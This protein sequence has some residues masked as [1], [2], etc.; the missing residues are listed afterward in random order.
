MKIRLLMLAKDRSSLGGVVNFVNILERNL[1]DDVCVEEF[2]IGL[3]DNKSGKLIRWVMPF[4]DMFRLACRILFNRYDV[5]QINPSLNM[6][7][8]FRDALFIL[9]IKLRA[10]SNVVLF[11]HGWEDKSEKTI[12]NCELLKNIFVILFGRA[13]VIYVLA[14]RFKQS[15]VEWGVDADKVH[16]ITTMFDGEHF[17]GVIRNRENNE[18]RLLYLSRFVKEKGVYELLTSFERLYKRYPYIRLVLAGEGPEGKGMQDWVRNS[19][20]QDVVTFVGYVR[21]KDKAQV[22]VDSDIFV[23]PTYYAEGCPVSLLE[24][25]AAGLPIVTSMVGG[26]GDII[27]DGKNGVLLEEVTAGTVETA[28]QKLLENELMRKETGSYNKKIAWKHYEA[29]VISARIE[30]SYRQLVSV[31]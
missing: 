22:L 8:L 24:A 5:I 9:V 14:S 18:I 23:F 13:H 31:R 19:G 26:I 17:N 6:R 16:V 1:S 29:A 28:L 11:V 25:M 3:R 15:L 10:I 30:K 27:A 2:K 4:V 20:L 12:G 21:D 7:S